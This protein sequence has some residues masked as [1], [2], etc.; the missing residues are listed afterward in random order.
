MQA[1]MHPARGKPGLTLLQCIPLFAGLPEGQL[2]Q[3][4]RMAVHRKVPRN[5]TIVQCGR[6]YRFA[7]RYRQRQRESAQ[8]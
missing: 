3:L 2:A 7:F 4:A 6:R 8:S 1:E 5:T